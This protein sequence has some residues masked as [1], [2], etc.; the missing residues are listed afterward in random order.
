MKKFSRRGFIEKTVLSVAGISLA[1]RAS[2]GMPAIIKNLGKPNSKFGDI[3]VGAITYSFRSMPSN[4]EQVLEYC[5]NS[6]IS[7]IELMGTTAEAFAGAPHMS[8]EPRAPLAPG[9]QRPQQTPEQKAEEL[10]K[11][12]EIAAWRSAASMEKFKQ[13]RKMYHDAGVSIYAWKPSALGEKNSDAEIRYA[14][15]VARELGANQVTVELPSNAAQSK[16]LGDLAREEKMVVAYHGHLQ[17]TITAWDEALGQSSYNGINCDI[18]HYVAAGFDP[19]PLL[20][21]KHDRIYSMHV[22]DRKSKDHGGANM[23]WGEGDTPIGQALQLMK[24]NKYT[25]PATVELEYDIPSG[26]DAVKEVAKCVEFCRKA[27]EKNS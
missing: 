5:L 9:A 3:Q 24:K 6:N 26:S 23:P 14:L 17:Q 4:A 11:A 22:K 15:R 1:S 16:R 13:L 19:I 18:G 8:T 25:F 10:A 27:L 20:E 2:F 12:K 21:S 7:A